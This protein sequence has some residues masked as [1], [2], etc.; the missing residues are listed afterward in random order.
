V[1][2]AEAGPAN[3]EAQKSAAKS[4]A[5]DLRSINENS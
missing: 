5:K 3:T 1:V 4:R 2:R